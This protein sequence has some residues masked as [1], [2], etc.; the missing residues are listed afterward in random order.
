M[1]WL[2][3]RPIIMISKTAARRLRDIYLN[4]MIIIYLRDISIVVPD[5]QHGSVKIAAQLD[6]IVIDIDQEYIYLGLPD[7][8]V[9]KTVPHS[10]VGL[11]EVGS[12]IDDLINDDMP[13]D[14][15]DV[16]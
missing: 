14:A 16:H 6:G 1:I 12:M 11:I 5:E 10:S 3:E 4:E 8:S 13:T 2:N 9:L 7:G 15:E